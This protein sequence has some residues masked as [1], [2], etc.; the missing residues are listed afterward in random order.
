MR[1]VMKNP[2][3]IRKTLP[4]TILTLPLVLSST[5]QATLGRARIARARGHA[6]FQRRYVK[7]GPRDRAFDQD[8]EMSLAAPERGRG[9]APR[10]QHVVNRKPDNP[11][12]R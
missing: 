6:L 9:Q 12:E 4:V 8:I 10:E 3:R 2:P 11:A 5:P 7:R 1:F